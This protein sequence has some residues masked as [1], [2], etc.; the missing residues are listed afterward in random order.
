MSA[1]RT[2]AQRSTRSV[3]TVLFAVVALMGVLAGPAVSSA[4]AKPINNEEPEVQV[5]RGLNVGERVVCYPG[6]W[7]GAGITFSYAWLRDGSKIASGDVY[8]LT[9]ADEGE[10]LSCL[11]TATNS[12]GSAQELSWNSVAVPGTP[13][14]KP[15]NTVR[16]EISGKAALHEKLTCSQGTWE[17]SPAPTYK[18]AWLR[19]EVEIAGAT[20]STHEVVEA[21]EGRSISCKVTAENGHGS[22]SATSKKS[23]TIPGIPPSNKELPKVLGSSSPVAGETL[24]CSVGSWNGQPPPSYTYVWLREVSGVTTAISTARTYTVVEADETHSLYC[25]VTATNSEGGVERHATA[26]SAGVRVSG[27]KPVNVKA[28]EV[29]GTAALGNTVTCSPGEWH[30][31]PPPTYTYQW[32][33]NGTS[34][35][36]ATMSTYTVVS[37]DEAQSLSCAVTASNS[38]GSGAATSKPVAV[39]GSKPVNTQAPEVSGTAAVGDTLTCS[40]GTWTGVPTPTFAYE[41]LREG[42]AIASA[43]A[44]AYTAVEADET[45]SL[46]CRVTASNS[47]GSAQATSASVK[48]PGT[49]P[50]SVK[51]PE[52]TGTPE[53]GD[54]LSCSTGTWTGVPT[55]TFA[56]Q[57]LREGVAIASATASTHTVVEGDEAQSLSCQVTATNSLGS[58]VATSASVNVGGSAPHNT[59]APA[60]SGTPSV[61]GTLTCS[62]GTWSGVPTP[63]FAYQWLR[64]GVVITSA[65]ASAYIV[66]EADETHSLSC[67]VKATNALGSAEA[68]SPTLKVAG[69]APEPTQAPQITG[70]LT[71]GATL[72]CS[73]GTWSGVPAPSFVYRWLREGAKI[74]SA[75]KSTYTIVEADE[76]HY[77][78]CEVTASNGEGEATAFSST[79]HVPGTHPEL[80][81]SPAVTGIPKAGDTL[82]CT[83][84][85]WKGVPAPTYAYRW[86]REGVT[87]A[88]ATANTYLL[89]E[90]DETHQISCKVTATNSEGSAEASTAS[91]RIEGSAPEEIK[92]PEVS[93][94]PLV[95]DVLSCSQGTWKGAPTPTYT[96]RWMRE[97]TEVITGATKSTYTV[98]E[99]DQARSLSC[100]VTASNVE[101]QASATSNAL[102]VGGVAP[103]LLKAPEVT[104]SAVIGSTLTCSPGKWS[105]VPTPSYTYRWLRE[106]VAIAA[107]TA[108]TYTVAEADETHAISCS[109]KATNSEGSAEASSTNSVRVPGSA[110]V[111]TKAPEVSGT[112]AVGDAL[113]CSHGTWTGTPT[114]TFNYQWLRAGSPISL[115]TTSSYTVVEADAGRTLTCE[116]TATNSE[117]KSSQLSEGVVVPGGGSGSRPQNTKAPEV[118][119]TAALGGMLACSQ[120]TW[121]GT[122]TPT[123]AYSW[124]RE[125]APIAG[126]ALSSYT[127][128]EADEGHLLTC[129]VSATNTEGMASATSSNSLKIPGLAP[130]DATAP[131]VS[132]S[133]VIGETLTCS[134]GEW[135]GAP[136]PT[137]T[138]EWLLEGAAVGSGDSY[139]VL[140]E[141]A[142]RSLKCEVTAANSEGHASESSAALLVGGTG[143]QNTK[144][145]AVSGTPTVGSTLTCSQGTWTGAPAPTYA[146][147]WMREGA[148]IAGA[149]A[150]TYKVLEADEGYSLSCEVTATNSA[151]MASE[152][153]SN[154]LKVAGTKPEEK[155]APTVSGKAS[156]GETLT[157]ASG[158]WK[159]APAPTFTYQWLLEGTAV[160]TGNTYLL[161]T[162][163]ADRSLTCKVTASNSEGQASASSAAI[164]VTGKGPQNTSPPEVSGSAAV[165]ATLTCSQ[166]TWI[167]AP[168]PTFT[169]AWL[170]EGAAIAGASASTYK[171]LE[172]D[173]GHSLSCKVTATNNEGATSEPS[174]NSVKVPGLAPEDRTLPTISGNAT[175]G[176]TLS[177][178]SGEWKGA[179]APSFTY[180]WLLEGTLVASSESYVVSAEA[181]EQTVV[182][183]V[184]ASNSEGQ[185]SAKSAQLRISGSAPV[186]VKP[187]EVSG[188]AVVGATLTCS[189]GTWTGAPT[190]TLS[191]EWLRDDSPIASATASTYKVASEDQT[192][193]LSCRVTATNSEGVQRDTSTAV[194]IPGA[195]PANI[196]PPT[197][198]GAAVVGET[199][200]CLAG[201]WTGTPAPAISYEWLLEGTLVVASGNSYVLSAQDA[202]RSVSCKVT[203][204]NSEGQASASTKAKT[205]KGSPPRS[206]QAPEVS[207]SAVLGSKLTCSTGTWSGAPAPTVFTYQW[208]REIGGEWSL[209]AG[210]TASTYTVGEADQGRAIACRV[211]AKSSEGV[212]TAESEPVQV[213]GVAPEVE[214]SGPP[215]VSGAPVVGETLTCSPGFWK[216]LP[217]PKFSYEWML[218]G[219][220]PLTAGT[221]YVVT[222]EDRGHSLSCTVTAQNSAGK[223][224]AQSSAL[225][226]PGIPPE[227]EE[228]PEVTH[229]KTKGSEQEE[230]AC[231]E[232]KWTGAPKP[233]L[234]Y[235][236]LREG[237]AIESATSNS[238]TVGPLD[239]GRSISCEVI[240]TNS[241]GRETATSNALR[242]PG[243]KP[244]DLEAP[245]VTGEP[246]VGEKLKCD[247]GDWEG[248]P[249]PVFQ[250]E[251]LLDGSAIPSATANTYVTEASQ[252]GHTISCVVTASN[253]EGSAT[254]ASSNSPQI[255]VRPVRKLEVSQPPAKSSVLPSRNSQPTV[256]QM[257]ASLSTQLTAALTRARIPVLLK[258]AG[259]AFSF[260]APSPGTLEVLW[261]EVPKG[262]HISAKSK[263][264]LVAQSKSFF[265]SSTKY[266]V[267]LHLTSAGRRL[268]RHSKKVKLTAKGIFVG[269]SNTPVTWL[270]NFVLGR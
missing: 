49:K 222:R 126:A 207:G 75:T 52:V 46:S 250:Y 213:A 241:A 165:G 152:R 195:K 50:V 109:V 215:E 69:S 236:W 35:A 93:G 261:Y 264:V 31:Q 9:A 248:A 138:Y 151:G 108:S 178:V 259:Y 145:P 80:I 231:S 42:T 265:T 237:T 189:P 155:T 106:G 82:T 135:S 36:L 225:A 19:E 269:H 243:V 205:V 47:A 186:N 112:P 203:A 257:L 232:G 179:P 14:T 247:A 60:L 168:A 71:L 166:G 55:P 263:P 89:A 125:G 77:L 220:V 175:V 81:K 216:G 130:R 13:G 219:I 192:H 118:S 114:P 253:N 270:K 45:H 197:V 240:A 134:P 104:G 86:L 246:E 136:T 121:T 101:G 72:T 73:T 199:L 24:T 211:T 10:T 30:G 194:V 17:G 102:R 54:V 174:I 255:A 193:A 187:P 172:A 161:P 160:A 90:A 44:A 170:R 111:N 38:E 61:G 15:R 95:G 254:A 33:R 262:A 159:G 164:R 180:R 115:A 22:E 53:P 200:T 32:L 217:T 260:L 198:T 234:T 229:V 156:V 3:I 249:P 107:A 26:K 142:G 139:V 137:F 218:D 48:V 144:A 96:Y 127:V 158:E 18:Y 87:I 85:E 110:P 177:C 242:V 143:P 11:V 224:F 99:A 196:A 167:A 116:V 1:S 183:E 120:G 204:T 62:T 176:E 16:P 252:L 40:T 184:T 27:S 212:N 148:A 59:V 105:G 113:T 171:V 208:R 188:S 78:S 239:A 92:A 157:C 65:T 64:E 25:E 28:P 6:S 8:Y 5:P 266:T 238:Y 100:V 132:G 66:A 169:Y 140:S 230:L 146:Y 141:D 124:L 29:T 7:E 235:Q 88:S 57:W 103:A 173:E 91:V 210:A 70:T 163:D 149:S 83:Q 123:F 226:I 56:Y 153:S 12:E 119:G 227:D 202:T 37:A 267:Q 150:S 21:D 245:K 181:D 51:A 162:E 244:K 76:G 58:A 98:A 34:I 131:T 4:L 258:P 133:A 79:V 43:S 94:T 129:K 209:I 122:P 154:A 147:L 256:A 185:A 41:W 221:S 201:E 67:R 223:A 74:A 182:C 63:T 117:G 251:W 84:G 191:Y 23:I 268:I 2:F 214:A 20:A 206:T 68:T 128:V 228:S 97:G 190:P 39:G 233:T